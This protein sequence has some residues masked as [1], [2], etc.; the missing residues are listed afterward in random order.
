MRKLTLILAVLPQFSATQDPDTTLSSQVREIIQKVDKGRLRKN[1]EKLVTFKQRNTLANWEL[2]TEGPGAAA[3]WLKTELESASKG[4]KMKASVEVHSYDARGVKAQNVYVW[5]KAKKDP[6]RV[7]IF[8][9]H[10][11]SCAT[12][13]GR[14]PALPAPGANDNGSGTSAVL[15]LTR[16]LAGY[17]FETSLIL[18]AFSGEEQGLLGA[19]A[20]S[21]HL[22]EQS[23]QVVG[24]V[25]ADIIGGSKGDDGA[26]DENTIRCFSVGPESSSHRVLARYIKGVGETYQPEF[27]IRIQDRPDRPGR[28]GD[29][30]A[31]SDAGFTAARVVSTLEELRKQHNS[32]DLIDNV[33]F[34]YLVRS[35]RLIASVI[36]NL[37][38]GPPAPEKVEAKP[39][40]VTIKGAS[41]PYVVFV[42]KSGSN[43]L[44]RVVRSEKPAVEIQGLA[45]GDAVSVS[46]VG[47]T[48]EIGPPSPEVV[49]E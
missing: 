36:A 7:V 3:R 40:A 42:R 17:S 8:G 26:V 30:Q 11:D 12:K 19:R 33:D 10:F 4:S 5:Y 29:H 28:G 21:K 41:G 1:I 34:E 39:G 46:A 20:F 9:A 44:D 22:K 45:A 16:I 18:I 13:D 32:R 2:A 24:M 15:E 31:F 47:K 23:F 37:A 43:D 35:T 38:G 25:N 27:K 49:V 48:G 14:D 6:N